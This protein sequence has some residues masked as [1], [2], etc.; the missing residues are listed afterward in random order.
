[1]KYYIAYGSNLN[2][3]A[4]NRR[5]PSAVPVGSSV[6]QNEALVFR[7]YANI[8]PKADSVV[9]VGIWQISD[10]D[11]K[12]LD[13]YE[14]YPKLYR[15]E[16]R[17]VVLPDGRQVDAMVYV[18]NEGQEFSLPSFTYLMQI[19]EGYDDFGLEK[20]TD[21]LAVASCGKVFP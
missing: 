18:M 13:F 1:M 19:R 7:G 2:K 8:E 15:K 21:I 6:L 16:T 20:Y 3:K 5:C 12:A 14:C 17:S 9:P 4:M 10:A 11:E